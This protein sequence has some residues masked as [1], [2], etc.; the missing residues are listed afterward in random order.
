MLGI[1][2]A[3]YD[4][5]GVSDLAFRTPDATAVGVRLGD[6]TGH[7]G[8]ATM[9]P[10][11]STVGVIVTADFNGDG[12]PDLANFDGDG[13]MRVLPNTTPPASPDTYQAELA[14]LAG[15]A[16]STRHGGYTGSGFVDF[17]NPAGDSAEF[18]VA[19]PSA[20][21]YE[22]RFRYAN[23]SAADRAMELRVNDTVVPA[24]V[25]FARTGAW[26]TWGDASVT[27]PL[28]AGINRVRLVASGQ[29]GPN[30]DRLV[31]RAAEPP[32]AATYQAEAATLSGPLALSDVA[33]FTGSGF[34]DYRHARGDYVEFAIDAGAA[35]DYALDFRY[36][37]GSASDRPLELRVDGRVVD[38]QMSFAPTGS[39]RTWKTVGRSLALG[40]GAHTVRLTSVGSNGPNLDA[41]AVTR[42]PAAP[43]PATLQAEAATLT[44]ATV[45][46]ARPGFTGTGYADYQ[47]ASGDSVEFSYDAPAAGTYVLDFRFANGSGY[48]RPLRLT[49]NGAVAQPAVS[50]PH[51]GNWEVWSVTTV[52]ATLSAGVNRIR[53]TAT[54]NSGPNLDAMTVTPRPSQGAVTYLIQA[55][56]IGAGLNERYDIMD[57]DT[58]DIDRVTES[59]GDG[60]SAPD[61]GDFDGSVDVQVTPPPG[62]TS[63]RAS[64]TQHSR[65]AADGI[66]VSGEF[67][68]HTATDFGGY[69][70]E[71]DL[72]V[73]FDLLQP[74]DY[75]LTYSISADTS[76][77]PVRSM[78]LT[79]VV[80]GA[81]VFAEVPIREQTA[82]GT[83][84]GTLAP[85][86]YRFVFHHSVGG[87]VGS[88]GPYSVELAL[89]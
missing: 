80:G 25:T 9:I 48:D 42:R 57:P 27:V 65:L 37:N 23:G 49:V 35:G 15:A 89:H 28:L 81:T 8:P 46:R 50:F 63:G 45:S 31:V 32:A 21:R 3:D 84:S 85:G 66:F 69:G 20:G 33:G 70:I 56:R 5:D 7:F 1:N 86:R 16:V 19:A 55:R 51:T 36:A 58:G 44:G 71:S 39:W 24:G 43:G 67:D 29:S 14:T 74:R 52:A 87:D 6:G 13:H 88:G 40:A 11:G 18:A 73:T 68:G 61:F 75:V 22:L 76:A 41:L 38:P 26:S 4:G 12:R 10:T 83:R 79:E 78:T 34:A 60:R 59:G 64:G 2:V 30:V 72:D 17:L 53:L 47:N 82:T 62:W 77:N 54:G